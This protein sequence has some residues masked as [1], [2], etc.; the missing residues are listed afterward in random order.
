MSTGTNPAA[1]A[2]VATAGTFEQIKGNVVG[3]TKWL[4]RQVVALASSVRDFAAKIVAWAKPFFINIAKFIGETYGKVR[5]YI[6]A[7]KEVALPVAIISLIGAALG[8]AS[9]FK[10]EAPAA[11]AATTTTTTNA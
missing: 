3:A 5:E 10:G 2:T 6:V 8:I 9:Y 7:H 4:G 1:G 11:A